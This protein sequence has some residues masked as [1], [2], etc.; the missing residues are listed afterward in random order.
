MVVGRTAV[1]ARPG[2]AARLG[3][4]G[5]VAEALAALGLAVERLA[6][7]AAL[8]GGDVLQ[9]PGSRHILVRQV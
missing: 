3:E 1:V 2:A 5:P 7:P 8:D 4:E 6:P 9:L